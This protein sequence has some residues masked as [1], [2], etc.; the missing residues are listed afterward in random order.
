MKLGA[1]VLAVSGGR[2]L[3]ASRSVVAAGAGEPKYTRRLAGAVHRCS[4]GIFGAAALALLLAG[5]QPAAPQGS[6][7]LTQT[8]VRKSPAPAATVMDG[9]YPPGS[10]VVL[11]TPPF[12]A[13]A[14]RE[15]SRGLVAAG[16]PCVS[17]DGRWIYFAGKSSENA[18]WQ[19]YKVNAGGGR[20]E[21]V[22]RMPGGA[23]D[24][25]LAAHEELVFSSPVPK[26]GRL[27]TARPPAAL[28]SQMPGQA[29]HRLTFGPQSAVGATVLRDG[30]ILFV[31][32]KPSDARHGPRH[33]GLFTI[34]NDG[35]EVTAYACQ[36][37]GAD[38]IRRP[39]ELGDG[40]VAFLAAGAGEEPGPTDAAECVRPAAPFATRGKL[41]A[42]DTDA[43]R[44]VEPA[45]ANDL[46]VCVETRGM[47]GRSMEGNMAV[48]RVAPEAGSLGTPLFDDPHWNSIEAAVVAARTEPA[49]HTSAVIPAAARG[50]VLC[51]DVNDSSTPA[52]GGNP[53]PATE[54]RVFAQADS[55][56]QRVLGKVP[57]ASDGSVLV[58][59][60]VGVPLGFET[61]DAQGNVLRHQ[62]AFVW[63]QSGE[64]RGCVGCHEPRNHS[65]RNIR[66][67]AAASEP[68]CLDLPARPT[69]PHATAP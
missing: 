15:L 45:P 55:G 59:L 6:L 34:N 69:A 35:T 46:L 65:P 47:F 42:F 21:P 3:V 66:P 5:C 64:N 10:R 32:A 58:Q 11:L 44:S 14:V 20:P 61:L 17:W 26:A 33:L 39:R 68:A 31:T 37:D 53:S 50:T 25:A 51:L 43:C 13:D 23:M 41:F 49:G 67:L 2:I 52:A 1:R 38:F 16:D 22:T 62:P 63:L 27:W 29:P 48:Y 9:R 36:D 24:P 40:R 19:I 7:V 18:D 8:P 4:A 12:R 30:R 54:L 56:Q 28:Y 60:P 57:V